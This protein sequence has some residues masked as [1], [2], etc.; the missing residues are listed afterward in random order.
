MPIGQ[1]KVIQHASAQTVKSFYERWYRPENMAIVAT[2]DFEADKV[3]E[4]I[5]QQLSG[6]TAASRDPTPPIPT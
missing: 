5:K 2:G 4:I 1:E 3:V 6:A